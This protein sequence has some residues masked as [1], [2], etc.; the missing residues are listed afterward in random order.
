[1]SGTK[2]ARIVSEIA[3]RRVEV[4]NNCRK[5]LK[6]GAGCWRWLQKAGFASKI[7]KTGHSGGSGLCILSLF[8]LGNS[9]SVSVGLNYSVCICLVCVLA[10]LVLEVPEKA[11]SCR[12]ARKQVSA[13]S[14]NQKTEASGS[15]NEQYRMPLLSPDGTG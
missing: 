4:D 3:V 8:Q 15:L 9:V 14:V 11:S 2:N 7:S 6:T 5:L 10:V 12:Y 1:V 13:G